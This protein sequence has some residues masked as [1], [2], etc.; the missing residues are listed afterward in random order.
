M[1]NREL[2][3]ESMP[4]YKQSRFSWLRASSPRR[5]TSRLVSSLTEGMLIY[6]IRPLEEHPMLAV[7]DDSTLDLICV[8]IVPLMLLI[9]LL[10]SKRRM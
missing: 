9:S 4:G 8:I 2:D 6:S 10:P 1:I 7:I 5:K 3:F